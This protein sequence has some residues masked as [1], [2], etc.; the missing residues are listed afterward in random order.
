ML[1]TYAFVSAFVR[2]VYSREFRYSLTC[3]AKQ[4]PNAA[5]R[6]PGPMNGRSGSQPARM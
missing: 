5:I 6:V 3:W 2:I 4:L 1:T